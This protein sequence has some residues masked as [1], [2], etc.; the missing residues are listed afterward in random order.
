[1]VEGIASHTSLYVDN[2]IYHNIIMSFGLINSDATYQRIVNKLFAGILCIIMEA[3]V[4]NIWVKHVKD[5]THTKDLRK[6]FN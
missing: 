6:T 1:M 5:V 3:Y 2:D 4:N